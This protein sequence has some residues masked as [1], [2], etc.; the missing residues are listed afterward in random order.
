[1]SLFCLLFLNSKIMFLPFF[2]DFFFQVKE[3]MKPNC[4]YGVLSAPLEND[5]LQ[6]H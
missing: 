5:F 2:S 3:K 6:L 1:M 4:D